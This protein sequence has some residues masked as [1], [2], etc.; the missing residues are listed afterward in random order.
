MTAAPVWR[1]G[2]PLRK[3]PSVCHCHAPAVALE[4]V[5]T[6]MAKVHVTARRDFLESLTIARP[7]AALAE[8]IWN[9]FDAQSDRVEVH[10][11]LNPM[12]GIESIRV[13]D[14]GSGIYHP[15]VD[16]L[17]GNLGDSWKKAKGRNN[18]RSLHGK[19]GKGRFKA[20]SLGQ[21]VTWNTTYRENG[22]A[23]SFQ[24]VGNALGLDDFET[25][26]PVEADGAA[27]GT[28]VIVSD[29][30]QEFGSLLAD[31]AP[32]EFAKVFA[33]YL[34]QYPGLTLV[35]HGHTI[36][37]AAAQRERF[38]SPLGNVALADGTEV[39]VALTIV[40]WAIPTD[41]VIHLCDAAGNSLHEIAAGPQIK[42]PGFAFT[43]S[44]KTDRFRELETQNLLV[45]ADLQPDVDALV[46][47]ARGMLKEHFRRRQA[48][49]ESR[50]VERWK[51]EGIYPYADKATL[52]PAE[53][54]ER[55][56][57]DLVAANVQRA[58]PAFEEI[59]RKSRQFTFRLLAQALR[60]NPES[61]HTIVGEVL[62]VAT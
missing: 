3:T 5:A 15:H 46:K 54:A 59:D 56:V 58:L 32:H 18:G 51:A 30:R 34:A 57:F 50:I 44:I 23:Y 8:L 52:D 40:E 21:S 12:G 2:V 27:T 13:R 62:G 33:P 36:D 7:I 9:G 22:K 24:I 43:A 11:D 60:E 61:V 19:F 4:C 35:Y 41:R 14:H 26:D 55:Q 53:L 29:I 37:P 10:L 16:A 28:E 6:A 49:D 48:E 25:T 17:F 42:A 20:F 45:L 39:P 1:G 47:A 38:E 31:S